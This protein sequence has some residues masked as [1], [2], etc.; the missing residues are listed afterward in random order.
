MGREQLGSIQDPTVFYTVPHHFKNIFLGSD[1]L[2]CMIHSDNSTCTKIP[3]LLHD[4]YKLDNRYSFT[5]I[6][7]SSMVSLKTRSTSA[8]LCARW[9]AQMRL[10]NAHSPIVTPLAPF[11]S[12]TASAPSK[13][14]ILPR[15]HIIVSSMLPPHESISRTHFASIRCRCAELQVIDPVY[16]VVEQIVQVD[17]ARLYAFQNTQADIQLVGHGLTKRMRQLF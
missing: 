2:S 11:S 4:A 9:H 15:A 13:S 14:T 5:F 16:Q 12:V 7:A 8:C 3:T 10:R 17:A 1:P 6:D